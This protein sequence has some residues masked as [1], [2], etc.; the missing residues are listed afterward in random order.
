[1]FREILN[2]IPRIPTGDL[3]RM[4]TSLNAR[5]G[6][7]AK[8]FGKGLV[9]TLKGG[10]IAGVALGLIEKLLNPFDQIKDTIETA[11]NRADDLKTYSA[12]FN[13][14]SGKL[15]KLETLAAAKGLDSDQ[16]RVLIGKFQGAVAEA[17]A[18]PSKVTA[19]RN[20]AT[21]G[22]DTAEAFFKFIQSSQKL[23]PEAQT[24]VQEE[25]F[26]EKL[27]L[28]ASEFFKTTPQEFVKLARQVAP[29]SSEAYTKV[30]DRGAEISD[31][32]DALKAARARGHLTE[33]LPAITDGMVFGINQSAAMQEL[34]QRRNLSKF[35]GARTASDTM[36]QLTQLMGDLVSTNRDGTAYLKQ[37]T[38]TMSR[39]PA[40]KILRGV[41]PFGGGK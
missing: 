23:K 34:N 13:T 36:D 14:T 9:A 24:L 39:I 22:Q 3:N 25:I 35:Q 19:V 27:A 4:E 29:A 41:L 8:R 18:D 31:K 28:K 30:I 21:P 32:N 26:G 40:L 37:I 12:Q 11:L 17:I 38:D 6:R 16:L 7:I 20:F 33:A 15:L 5:F 2:I 10:G 1:M